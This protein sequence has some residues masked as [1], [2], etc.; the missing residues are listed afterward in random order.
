MLSYLT[1][2]A[3]RYS[4][5]AVETSGLLNKI[6]DSVETALDSKPLWVVMFVF[7]SIMA[8]TANFISSTVAAIIFLPLIARV[9]GRAAFGFL[10]D[11]WCVASVCVRWQSRVPP[12][13]ST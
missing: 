11:V 4:T 5:Q 7:N 13:L 1:P 10:A 3:Q 12:V 8:V 9:A 6:A 2:P